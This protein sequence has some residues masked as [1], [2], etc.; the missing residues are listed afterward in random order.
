MEPSPGGRTENSKPT[1]RGNGDK[2]NFCPGLSV[3]E[4]VGTSPTSPQRQTLGLY[5]DIGIYHALEA[6]LANSTDGPLRAEFSN[7]TSAGTLFFDGIR[8]ISEENRRQ[9]EEEKSRL[10]PTE[11]Y[12]LRLRPDWDLVPEDQ[13][14]NAHDLRKRLTQLGAE[15][16]ENA[17]RSPLLEQADET[18]IRQ[19]LRRMCSALALRLYT[20]QPSYVVEE[21]DKIFGIAPEEH[22][23][24]EG[25]VPICAEW[26]QSAAK[27]LLEKMDLLA[28]NPENLARAIVSSQTPSVHKYRPNTA[29]IM[30]QISAK[31]P[32]L[33]DVK[34]CI[35]DVFKNFGITALRSDEIEHSDVITQRILD[36][37][38]T[39]E[40]LIADLSGERPS[41]YY[42]LGYAHAVGKRP[43]MYRKEGTALHF[44]LLVHNVPEYKNTTDLK[45]KLTARLEAMTNRAVSKSPANH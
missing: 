20:Y 9:F 7:I 24:R 13:R 1:D 41:V 30:M 2:R 45:I 39:A 18:E 34:N 14:Q 25:T 22:Q 6:P 8:Q 5:S 11:Y 43:I 17:R 29:F 28:P 15:I 31:I 4:G 16:I 35:K 21:R 37:I 19:S 12:S 33:E 36:E 3:I 23:E 42:E 32:E 26:F 44:D 40:F 38:A 27:Q 10:K